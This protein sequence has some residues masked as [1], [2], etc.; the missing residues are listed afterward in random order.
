VFLLICMTLK[1]EFYFSNLQVTCVSCSYL[2]Y[3]SVADIVRMSNF[4]AILHLPSAKVADQSVAKSSCTS[5]RHAKWQILIGRMC[6]Q[7]GYKR[8]ASASWGFTPLFL[9]FSF[10]FLFVYNVSL[11]RFCYFVCKQLQSPSLVRY[12]NPYGPL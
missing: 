6:G 4:W 12:N 9:F 3:L 5:Q 10:I 1:D 2:S 8:K 11:F 7:N